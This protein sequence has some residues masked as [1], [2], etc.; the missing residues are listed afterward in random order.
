[1]NIPFI[2]LKWQHAQIKDALEKRLAD[3]FTNTS[4]VLGPDVLLFEEHFA[5]Y[6]GTRHAVGVSGG[7]TAL[8]LAIQALDLP[9]DSEVLTLPTSFF[10]SA[11]AIIHA[12]HR[13]IFADINLKTGNFDYDLL[14]RFITP[15]TK[16]IVVVHLYGRP[17]NMDVISSLAREFGLK[18]IEDAAQAHGAMYKGK[19]VGVF[20]DLGCF[21]FYPGKNLGAYGDGGA[22]V[23]DSDNLAESIRRLRNHGCLGKYDHEIV[24]YNAKLDSIQA[25]VLD[26]KLR[27]LDT[28]NEMRRSIAKKY[29]E[30]LRNIDGVALVS[31]DTVDTLSVR[32][33]YILRITK[34]SR[35]EVMSRLKEVGIASGVHYPDPL[36]LL[37]AFAGLGY[38]SGDFPNA[39]KLSAQILSLPIFPGMT[40]LQVEYVIKSLED[41]MSTI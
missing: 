35:L 12:G 7:T 27:H 39:E 41:I 34:G 13:P 5:K 1:M 22:V 23:V 18:I 19:K 9:R 14:P 38:K 6:I 28:W 36:H 20:G 37:P 33:L 4:F 40:D 17:A 30:R 24:G 8:A 11:S 2:D 25:A 16:A 15:Q 29:D 10:A 32:H 3:I 21:S 31:T 26:E